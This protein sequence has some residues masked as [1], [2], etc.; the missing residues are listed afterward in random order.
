MINA[1]TFIFTPI[2]SFRFNK[3]LDATFY[4]IYWIFERVFD[5]MAIF[6]HVT[7]VFGQSDLP[8]K[9]SPDSQ[10]NFGILGL[11]VALIIN[12]HM[13]GKR[14]RRTILIKSYACY[15]PPKM[16]KIQLLKGLLHFSNDVNLFCIS[17][18]IYI[19]ACIFILDKNSYPF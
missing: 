10:K 17:T 16:A 12:F 15:K 2:A 9:C 7:E 6:D 18:K 11:I 8:K 1:T 5:K 3:K 19:F 4:N 14:I 13:S